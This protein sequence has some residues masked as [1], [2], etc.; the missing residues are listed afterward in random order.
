MDH[1]QLTL[2]HSLIRLSSFEVLNGY[3]AKTSF[4][5]DTPPTTTPKEKLNKEEAT[6]LAKC[7]HNG[8]KVAKD[9]MKKAQIKKSKNINPY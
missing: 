4:N 8:W 6:K 5:W 2:P 7:M 9:F 3:P 1:A